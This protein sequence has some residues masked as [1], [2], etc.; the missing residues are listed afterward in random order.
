VWN[1]YRGR[2]ETP[3][4]RPDGFSGDA[5]GARRDCGHCLPLVTTLLA[6]YGNFISYSK[7][8]PQVAA[9]RA[10]ARRRR[11]I[12]SSR[13]AHQACRLSSRRRRGGTLGDRVHS[14][15][16]ESK[17]SEVKRR[18]ET[19]VE[20]LTLG[21]DCRSLPRLPSCT[22]RN[23]GRRQLHRSFSLHTG[24]RMGRTDSH[25]LYGQR[26]CVHHRD[27][28]R[29]HVINEE[30][31]HKRNDSSCSHVRSGSMSAT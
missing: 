10:D 6:T 16:R 19:A 24:S 17:E 30:I 22:A 4:V 5:A 7:K 3:T 26:T 21:G 11:R 27:P 2:A 23:E 31:K 25:G 20:A 9:E 18:L 15:P 13:S 8:V 1:R 29:S 14:M 12:I 28:A